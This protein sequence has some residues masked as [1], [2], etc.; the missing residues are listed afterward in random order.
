MDII[1]YQIG[2]IDM[3]LPNKEP[4]AVDPIRVS[5][6]DISKDFD[7]S[8]FPILHLVLNVSKDMYYDIIENK[9]SIK[10]RINLNS[11]NLSDEKQ[12]PKNV[13][14]SLF[15]PFI[16]ENTPYMERELTKKVRESEGT[17]DIVTLRDFENIIELYLF[18]EEDII[19]AKKIT[20]VVIKRASMIDTI[21]YLFAKSGIKSNVLMEPLD[22]NNIYNDIIIPPSNLLANL[23]Y[24][25]NQ[26][27]LY[28]TWSTL[29]FDIDRIYLLS[30]KGGCW[31]YSTNE[32]KKV[33]LNVGSNTS[34]NGIY[35]TGGLDK[36]VYNFNITKNAINV[37][38]L[39]ITEDAII[40]NNTIMINSITGETE[41]IDSKSIDRGGNYKVL[42]NK[43]DNPFIAQAEK[44][45]NEDSYIVNINL[46]EFDMR[47]FTPNKEFII[48]FEE[49]KANK[50][51][52]GLY[53][54]TKLEYVFSKDGSMYSISGVMT[55]K[56]RKK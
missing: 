40:G 38:S 28:N 6:I 43:Y 48:Y 12:L 27:G 33:I 10:F 1:K 36:G 19:N 13:F 25:E 47:A 53:R 31:A 26:Y 34:P 37:S 32:P 51:F 2:G 9:T 54:L 20:N 41:K 44:N 49:E 17:K 50:E 52:G 46:K 3:I 45:D 7:S 11:L 56:R 35:S 16:D 55:L 14:N 29:F 22:N 30:K 8:F 23:A 24:L 18:K 21:T 39:S 4:I 5:A 15:T 42:V